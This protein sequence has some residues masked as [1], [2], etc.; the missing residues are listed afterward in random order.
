MLPSLQVVNSVEMSTIHS[1]M[2][3]DVEHWDVFA[4]NIMQGAQL[5]ATQF[6]ISYQQMKE[7]F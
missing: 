5:T 6:E 4:K 3:G 7:R 1:C 2:S